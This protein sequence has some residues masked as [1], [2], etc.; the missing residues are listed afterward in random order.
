MIFTHST[1]NYFGINDQKEF[2]GSSLLAK[3][4]QTCSHKKQK[5][6][7]NHLA[8]CAQVLLRTRLLKTHQMN[9]TIR[10][11]FR[12]SRRT[13]PKTKTTL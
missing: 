2:Y 6:S 12:I 3:S 4:H 5:S 13:I 10:L 8:Q 11:F 1:F 9:K 7:K